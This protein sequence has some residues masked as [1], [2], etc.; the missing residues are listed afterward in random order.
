[1]NLRWEYAV[2]V[3]AIFMIAFIVFS[4][5][6]ERSGFG[7][8]LGYTYGVYSKT[9][10]WQGI[11]VQYDRMKAAFD[12]G[13]YRYTYEVANISVAVDKNMVGAKQDKDTYINT[14]L[15]IYTSDM[16][17]LDTMPGVRGA[18]HAVAGDTMHEVY[19][20]IMIV[21]G[22]VSLWIMRYMYLRSSVVDFLKQ[23]GLSFVIAAIVCF[24]ALFVIYTVFVNPWIATNEDI[25][26]Q[27]LPIIANM[28]KEF[29]TYYIIAFGVIGALLMIPA[30]PQLLN[31]GKK[32]EVVIN[33]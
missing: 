18:I 9:D 6:W 19:G 33:K 32:E 30:I 26:H 20:A 27:G 3:L 7:S 31:K 15:S 11:N 10:D 17:H 21:F 4:G 28:I 25:Y 23:I 2:I 5:L 16:Y 1:M 12:Q 14:V 13:T 29:Y 24:V 22:L 8:M